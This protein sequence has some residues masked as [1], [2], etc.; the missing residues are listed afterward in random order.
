MLNKE[1]TLE[2]ENIVTRSNFKLGFTFKELGVFLLLLFL[3][4][5]L[6]TIIITHNRNVILELFVYLL[7]IVTFNYSNW[8]YKS[9]I[10]TGLI[11]GVYTLIN[12]SSYKLNVLM[13]L[14]IIQSVSGIRFRRYLL[15]N[16][17]ISGVFLLIMFIAYGEGY[18]MPGFAYGFERKTRMSF[19]FNQ[20]NV[21]ALHYFCFIVNGLLLVHFSKY[22]KKAYLYMILI[23]PLWFYI[24]NRTASR[25]FLLSMVTLYGTFIFYHAGIFLKE[26]VNLNLTKLFKFVNYSFVFLIVLFP[27]I[28]VFFGLQ[29]SSYLALDR[30]FSKRLTF[31]EWFL[32]TLT[33]KDFFFGSST[34][35]HYVID[36]S[37]LRLLFEGG[38]IFFLFICYFYILATTKMV[39][40]KAW[41]PICVILSFMFYGLMESVLLYSTLIGT[42]LFWITLY[43]Y[44]RDGKMKL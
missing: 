39:N 18:N 23:I 8:S 12:F 15:I 22:S 9:L 26:K 34:F 16:F 20:P 29:R 31:Y 14:L 44:Y 32:H 28:T 17:I 37:Y 35:K 38:F 43:Y 7:F 21:G 30:L 27:A 3:N 40:Q 13:P 33:P 36:S 10:K 19:G 11:I 5:K 1:G 41:V 25:S 2:Q 24:Y 6:T 42:N 4:I